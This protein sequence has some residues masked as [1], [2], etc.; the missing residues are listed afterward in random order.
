MI[1]ATAMTHPGSVRERNEDTVVIPGLLSAGGM[2]GPAS[3]RYPGSSAPLLFAVVDGMGG[4]RAGQTASRLIAQH[5]LDHQNGN[6]VPLLEQANAAVYAAMEGMPE[7]SGMGATI[8]GVQ[9]EGDQATVFNVGDVRVY[10]RAAE[11]LMLV[12]TDDRSAA[13]SN[14]ITQSMGGAHRLTAI[15]PHVTQLQ[16]THGDRLLVCSDGLSDVVPFDRIDGCLADS[17]SA[18]AVGGLLSEAIAAGA[19]DNVSILVL[20]HTLPGL[21]RAP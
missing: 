19:P 1:T 21:N 8:A 16:L 13:G 15:N 7:L 6:L 12:S 20:D 10:Q 5:L 9:I 18:A 4:H 2:P 3:L 11:Y 17:D 14:V